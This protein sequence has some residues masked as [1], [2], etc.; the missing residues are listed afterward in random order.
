[1][2]VV[3]A[4]HATHIPGDLA[5]NPGSQG[6]QPSSNK[7]LKPVAMV[8]KGQNLHVSISVLYSPFEILQ[9]ATHWPN[10]GLNR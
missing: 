4:G 2:V 3:P 9:P 5:L 7:P 6:V 10:A 8:P 1:M